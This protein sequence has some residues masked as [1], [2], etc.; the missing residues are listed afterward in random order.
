M[1]D[2]IERELWLPASPDDVWEA[3]IGDGWLADEVELEL[4]PGG[5]ASFRT[6]DTV[7]TGWVEEVAAPVPARVLVGRGRRA[8]DAG[9]AD[10]PRIRG[11][12][13]PAGRRDT[14]ARAARPRR[15]AAPRHRRPHVRAGA[16]RRLTR[17]DGEQTDP[18]HSGRPRRRGVRRAGRPDPPDPARRARRAPGG[19]GDRARGRAADHAPGGA[20]A[21]RP[22]SPTPACSTAS[23]PAA[24]SATR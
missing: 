16:R 5:E 3:V 18:P 17:V 7:K 19:D 9:R 10:A 12:G 22:R 14:P 15:D 21:S 24:R 11:R 20:Q 6:A 2:R 1:T 13:P 4:R 8:G 23:A